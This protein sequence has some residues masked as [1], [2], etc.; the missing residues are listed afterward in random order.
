MESLTEL[1][2]EAEAEEDAGIKW[3]KRKLKRRLLTF[4]QYLLDNFSLN[5]VKAMFTPILVIYRY[6]EIELFELPPINKKAAN[7][8]APIQFEDLPDK[9]IIRK[10]VDVATPTIKPII[11][12]MASSG[13]ARM[14]TLNLTIGDYIEAVSEYT[15]ETNIFDIIEDLGDCEGV[16]PTFTSKDKKQENSLPHLQS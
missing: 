12:F 11:L 14:E 6:Y 9:E 16:V 15:S 4:R 5:T 8:S 3:K 10:A 1:L 2:E 13:C 7:T